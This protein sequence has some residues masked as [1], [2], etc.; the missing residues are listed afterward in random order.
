MIKMNQEVRD[1]HEREY[2]KKQMLVKEVMK[3]MKSFEVA[4]QEATAGGSIWELAELFMEQ[5]VII[6]AESNIRFNHLQEEERL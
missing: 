5:L 4:V 2:E 6:M 3:V 1:A